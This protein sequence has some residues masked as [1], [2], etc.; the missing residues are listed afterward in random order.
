MKLF[1]YFILAVLMVVTFSCDKDLEEINRNPNNP[2]EVN[3]EL[4]MVTVIRGTVNQMVNEAWNT[5]NIV[6]QYTAE[7]REPGTDRYIWTGAFDTWSNGYT[8][9]RDVNNLYEIGEEREL[10]NYMGI[11]LVMRALIF[12][13]MTDVYGALPYSQALK[14]KDAEPVYSPEY[15]TQQNIYA[16]LLEELE[17]AN[18]LLS[19]DGGEIRNDIL[20]GNGGNIGDPMLW[21]KLANSLKLRLLMRQSNEVDPSQAIQQ[22][23]NNPGQYPIFTSN[24]DNATLTYVAAPNLFPITGTRIGFWKDRRLSKTLSAYLNNTNDPRLQVYAE[25]TSQSVEANKQGNGPLQWD[26]VRNGETDA[27]LSSSIDGKVST[28]GSIFYIDVDVPVKAEG[29]VMTYSEV[30][31]ILAEA[32]Q[33]GWISGS[34]ETYYYEGIRSS[35]DYYK[36]IS[37]KSIS[38]T[39]AFLATDSVRFE[40]ANATTLIGTQKWIALF[41]TD[42][43]AWH[44]WKRTGIPAFTPSIV[45]NNGDRIPVRSLYP[46]TQQVTNRTNYQKAIE[47]QGEDNIN[48]KLWWQ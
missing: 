38:A 43:Q 12:S 18:Q 23:L 11:A 39:D 22:I 31:F 37:G 44:E 5:G 26:G 29:I 6:A 9:L 34:A 24:S 17:R 45:N 10:N 4:L 42:L 13:R 27:N 41:F 21:R 28:L 8:V 32:A 2:E 7:V 46:T 1:R 40:T 20:Y 47:L 25:P 3:P 33:K 35:V 36:G 19:A 16:G 48:T 15:D 30:S 14:G